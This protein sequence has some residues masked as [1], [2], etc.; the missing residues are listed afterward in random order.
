ML[1]AVAALLTAAA[2]D[3]ALEV[4]DKSKALSHKLN[5]IRI[6]NRVP[7]QQTE[8]GAAA[9][10]ADIDHC[11]GKRAVSQTGSKQMLEGVCGFF[12]CLRDV[13]T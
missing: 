13:Q 12:S 3:L 9:H 4:R 8:P 11:V 2:R 7:Q 6:R 1:Q 5:R 10:G